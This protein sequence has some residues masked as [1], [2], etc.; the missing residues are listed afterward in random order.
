MYF[1]LLAILLIIGSMITPI[2]LTIGSV[3]VSQIFLFV[4][5]PILILL[6]VELYRE[7]FTI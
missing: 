1:N 3:E 7:S 4:I 5:I 2:Y 6:L